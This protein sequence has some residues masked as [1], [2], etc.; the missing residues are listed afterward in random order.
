MKAWLAGWFFLAALAVCPALADDLRL[1]ALTGPVVDEAGVLV[2]AQKNQIE[3]LIGQINATG[4]VQ[5]AV[6]IPASLQGRD[7]ESYSMAVAEAWKLGKSKVDNGLL[8]VVAPN[9]HRMRFETGYGIEGDLTD[10]QSKRIQTQIISPFF[11]RNDYF[12][13]I[14]AGL[15]AVARELHLDEASPELQRQ[16]PRGQGLGFSSI[17]VL[18][19]FLISILRI[20]GALFGRSRMPYRQRSWGSA[21]TGFA[22]GSILGGG[23]RGGGGGFGGGGFSGGGG[24]FGGGGSSSSW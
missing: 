16:V 7:I 6:V 1:P 12:G 20:F 17:F 2:G 24:G 19:F 18:V 13:G 3:Q 11:R 9:E 21:A 22:L 15:Y 10:V 23:R 5:V 14:E 8:V 4:K